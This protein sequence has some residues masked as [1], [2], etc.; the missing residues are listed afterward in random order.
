MEKRATKVWKRKGKTIKITKK[1]ER[2][3]GEKE[4][5][6]RIVIEEKRRSSNQGKY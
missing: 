6:R 4:G 2:F 1:I 3:G 5:N